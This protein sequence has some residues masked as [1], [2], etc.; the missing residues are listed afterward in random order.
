MQDTFA[1]YIFYPDGGP[2]VS[3][4]KKISELSSKWLGICADLLAQHGPVMNHNMGAPLSHIDIRMG[5]P[6]VH[7][8]AFEH[9]CYQVAITRG[10]GSEKDRAAVEQF[11]VFLE[12]AAEITEKTVDPA[13]IAVLDE[14]LCTQSVLVFDMCQPAVDENQKHALLDLGVHLAGAYYQYRESETEG[15]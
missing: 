10:E 9:L 1:L 14:A 4:E 8:M 13:A 11:K 15:G 12:T 2:P 5:G 6:T 7:L 3:G